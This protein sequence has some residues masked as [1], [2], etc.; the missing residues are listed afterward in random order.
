MA[1]VVVRGRALGNHRKLKMSKTR[2]GVLYRG[3]PSLLAAASRAP[4]AL[5]PTYCHRSF[6]IMLM[7]TCIT[8]SCSIAITKGFTQPSANPTK[9][10]KND[11]ELVQKQ[12]FRFPFLAL[13]SSQPG[14]KYALSSSQPAGCN[15][16][17]PSC[18]KTVSP[19]TSEINAGVGSFFNF[20]NCVS[21]IQNR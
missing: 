7:E 11:T 20:L 15:L 5:P 3:N 1:W 9:L 19:G 4:L 18:L 13:G 10:W 2:K 6:I 14:R 12:T 8:D 16:C 21:A 17:F